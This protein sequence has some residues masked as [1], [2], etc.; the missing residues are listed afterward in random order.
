MKRFIPA[1][2]GAEI[3]WKSMQTAFYEQQ[4]VT[5]YDE[6]ISLMTM[7]LKNDKAFEIVLLHYQ[8]EL[9][10]FLHRNDLY[11]ATYWSVFDEIQGFT[12]RPTQSVD[13]RSLNWSDH[14]EF[15]YTPHLVRAIES[16]ATYSNI[17]FNQEGYLNR[18]ERYDDDVLKF[19]YI[20]DDRGYLSSYV[21]YNNAAQP[22]YQYYMTIHGDWI[23]RED[24][25]H[26]EVTIAENYQSQFQHSTYSSME[27]IISE[28]LRH[29]LENIDT[30]VP[31]VV[32]ADDRHHAIIEKEI[33][34]HL[35]CFSIYQQREPY[36]EV[37]QYQALQSGDFILVD[38]QHQELRLK[39]YFETVPHSQKLMRITP[40]ATEVLPNIS[41][42]LYEYNIGVWIDGI[43]TGALQETLKYFNTYMDEDENIR[44]V[45]LRREATLPVPAWLNTYVAQVNEQRNATDVVS[46]EVDELLEDEPIEYIKV[47]TVPFEN[48][49]IEAMS[50]L[51]LTV[52]LRKEPDL[53]LQICGLSAGIPQINRQQ[54]EYVQ[55]HQN[56]YIIESA[57][58]LPEALDYFFH[59]LKNWNQSYAFSMKLAKHYRSD[60]ILKQ[61]DEWLEGVSYGTEN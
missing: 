28:R 23:M 5:E 39:H 26:G 15:I 22:I 42:Q 30:S 51:R 11:E 20:F 12:K 60:R 34:S 24:V 55:H 61:L 36:M 18:I 9:R 29:Y 50:T 43:T 13:Y 16:E 7:H 40:F 58:Q 59:H 48:D 45:L 4:S 35:L 54:T 37:P 47:Q 3:W 21:T 46:Q 1:W 14:T 17:Y 10:L 32:A 31:F 57:K 2:Y 52:D 38:T 25:M 8:P 19:S 56:G 44:I 53:Y 41:S 27:S 6:L 33:A 49:V